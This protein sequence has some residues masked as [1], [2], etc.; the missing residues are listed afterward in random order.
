MIFLQQ[1]KKC[2]HRHLLAMNTILKE[3]KLKSLLALLC[4]TLL[5]L[6]LFITFGCNA[7]KERSIVILYENDVHCNIDGYARFK[8]LADC[9]ADTAWVG[10]TSSGDYLHGGTAGAISEGRFIVDI[11]E[12]VGYDAVGLGNH[13]FDFGTEHLSMLVAESGLPVVNM[14]LR[15][16]HTDSLFFA[17]YV[18]RQYGDKR[19]AFVGVVTPETLNSEAYS[20]YDREGKQIYSLC[21]DNLVEEVQMAVNEARKE[22][23]D[24]VILLSH[25][26]ENSAKNLLTSHRLISKTRGIDVVFD[27][28]THSFIPCETITNADGKPVLVS[29]T[30]SKFKNVGKL[31]ILPDGRMSV[32]MIPMDSIQAEN[33][34][35]HEVTDIIKARMSEVTASLVGHSDFAMDI[36][37]E[38]GRQLVRCEETAIG[39][40]IADAMRS[41][42]GAQIAVNNGGGIRAQLPAGDWTY[43]NVVDAFPYNNYLMLVKVPGH[44]LLELLVATTANAPL[45]DGQF[46]QIS[47]FRF[48]LDV[49]KVGKDR[50]SKVEIMDEKTGRYVALKPNAEYIMCTT[51]YCVIGGGMYNVLRDAEIL[52]EN[53]MLYNQALISYIKEQLGGMIPE[54]YAATEGRILMK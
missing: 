14:N 33:Q 43:G 38:Q 4:R 23:V 40:L 7:P 36:Y 34:H 3:H 19:I 21:E 5:F 16:F 46:P 9:I 47:G 26:G 53:I 11:M 35:V 37:D 15:T 25:L 42:T 44:Q 48:T 28:H 49:R 29:Q 54:R 10:L 1:T 52:C 17:P 50:I 30:G 32:E 51:D 27:G 8:G 45:E 18:V 24:Y 22:E 13:E 12:E 39:N 6:F 2:K 31:L 41:V 20:F